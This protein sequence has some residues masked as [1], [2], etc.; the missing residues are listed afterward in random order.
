MTVAFRSLTH[1]FSHW[2]Q[3]KQGAENLISMY[4][5]T[6]DKKML[7]EA[8]QMLDDAR[9]KIEIVRMQMLRVQQA[10]KHKQ[11]QKLSQNNS[12]SGSADSNGGEVSYQLIFH[13][14]IIPPSNRVCCDLEP[15]G[16]NCLLMFL[17]LN[18]PVFVFFANSAFIVCYWLREITPN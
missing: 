3:V 7:A 17:C 18:L 16:W 2:L 14:V 6:R 15:Y 8:H 13:L 10:D 11:Q 9:T 12:Q 1:D 5:Q 4:T